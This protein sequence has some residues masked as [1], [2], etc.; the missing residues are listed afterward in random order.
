MI[1]NSITFLIFF[2]AFF[3]LYW[4]VNNRLPITYRNIFTILASYLFYGWWDYRFLSLIIA[5]SALDYSIGLMMSNLNSKHK[6]KLLLAASIVFNIGILGFFKYFNF[7]IDSAGSLLSL[8]SISVNLTSLNIIL[9]VGISFYTFQT[10]SYTIDVYKNKIEPTKDIFS[11]FAFVAFFP[12]LVAG[13]IERASRFLKQFQ[14][15]KSFS[16][17]ACVIGL[18]LI[19]WGLFKKIVIADNFGLLADIIFDTSFTATGLT[20]LVGA[21]FFAFQIYADFSGYSDMAIGVSKMLGFDLIKNFKTPYFSSSFAEFWRRWHISLSTWFRDYLYI[22][23]GGSRA[24]KYRVNLNILITFLVSGLWHGANLTF[25]IWGGL[26]GLLLIA[27]KQFK[28]KLNRY[29]YS[30]IVFTA[31]TLLW[32]P[33][34]AENFSHLAELSTSIFQFSS[35]SISVLTSVIEQFSILRFASL[36][37]VLILFLI[38]ESTLKALDFSEWINEKKPRFRYFIYYILIILIFL[39]G[40]FSVKPNFIYFQF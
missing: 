2:I 5:S 25:V 22:P 33:F 4:Q 31:V 28:L 1:F 21:L 38:L 30:V 24:K 10:L 3:L 16:Y 27:E 23:L 35:Y 12:Q 40:N 19:L 18:R 39:I 37:L 6:R 9:P 29:I 7:F 26:H 32:I 17:S 8:F 20:T 15:K 36:I 13:P 11:F 34:R 14:E